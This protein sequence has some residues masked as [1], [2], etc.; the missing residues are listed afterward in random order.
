M[1]LITV[2]KSIKGL[3]PNPFHWKKKKL[4]YLFSFSRK[5]QVGPLTKGW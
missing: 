1:V 4:F 3:V 2:V 5:S